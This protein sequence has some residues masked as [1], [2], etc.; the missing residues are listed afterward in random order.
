[1]VQTP[2]AWR[3]EALSGKA[4]DFVGR[5]DIVEPPPA[6]AAV[7]QLREEVFRGDFFQ[8]A[9]IQAFRRGVRGANGQG[10]V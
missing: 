7:P 6:P 2:L 8:R 10:L 4:S 3:D 5:L 9:G 1:M